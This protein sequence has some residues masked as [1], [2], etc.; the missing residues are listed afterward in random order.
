ML[1]TLFL[2]KH[3]LVYFAVDGGWSSYVCGSCSKT[4][5]GGTQSCTR[6]CS[7]PTPSCG[8]RN[9]S[10]LSVAQSICNA[11][12]CPGKF[13]RS[14]SCLFECVYMYVHVYQLELYVANTISLWQ[15]LSHMDM[16]IY[17]L[18]GNFCSLLTS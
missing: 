2:I 13:I 16:D 17:N 12:C 5:G 11:Q 1:V 6:R 14:C 18:I 9:C 10:G 8:G 4:C 3:Q 7:N 15:K